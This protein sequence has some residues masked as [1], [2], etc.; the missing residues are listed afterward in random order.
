LAFF[1]VGVDYD[2][3][4]CES[5]IFCDG[6]G[7]GAQDYAAHSDLRVLGDF[8]QVLEERAALVGEQRLGGAHAAGSAAR[9]D[10][11]G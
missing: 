3:I 1:P 7:V 6:F 10:Y 2:F 4:G 8:E 9:E 11:G 5:D